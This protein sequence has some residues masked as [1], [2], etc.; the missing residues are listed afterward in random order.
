MAVPATTLDLFARL[1][2]KTVKFE[3]EFELVVVEN[4]A[5]FID[6]HRDHPHVGTFHKDIHRGECKP[7]LVHARLAVDP[8]GQR[9]PYLVHPETGEQ[10][11]FH[12]K[13]LF[14]APE[15]YENWFVNWIMEHGTGPVDDEG[16]MPT[17]H[18][19][20][21]RAKTYVLK[22]FGHMVRERA[23]KEGLR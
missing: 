13:H 8:K 21:P 4:F 5:V 15:W 17:S 9:V 1:D 14:V 22:T 19:R 3:G 10:L 12:P 11:Q 16:K 6:T 2:H 7:T 18:F 23:L 20:D